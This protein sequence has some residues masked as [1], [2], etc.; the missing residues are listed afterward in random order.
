[1][2]SPPDLEESLFLQLMSLLLVELESASAS[3]SALVWVM[4]LV[5]L[6]LFMSPPAL[7]WYV[8]K[9]LKQVGQACTEVV[10]NETILMESVSVRDA[11]GPG[12]GIDVRPARHRDCLQLHPVLSP[13][14]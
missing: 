5:S 6:L 2:G 13:A 11:A 14:L 8:A 12:S 9:K 3:A 4:F 1:M 7:V 10:V